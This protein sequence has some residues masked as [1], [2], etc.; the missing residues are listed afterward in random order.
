MEI[1]VSICWKLQSFLK[2]IKG[3][4][5]NKNS[6]LL[7]LPENFPLNFTSSVRNKQ[8]TGFYQE[9]GEQSNKNN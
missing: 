3:K 6:I 4:L 9:R 8:D 7:E 2:N 1:G 5:D